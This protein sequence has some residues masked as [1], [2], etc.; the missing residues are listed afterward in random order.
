MTL[1]SDETS[2][3]RA[4]TL[5]Y[6]N[7]WCLARAVGTSAKRHGNT[8]LCSILNS[9]IRKDKP[10]VTVHAVVFANAINMLLVEDRAPQPCLE[11]SSQKN[12][13]C[14]FGLG[15]HLTPEGL[16]VASV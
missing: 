7:Y 15:R 1:L 14:V 2:M 12:I 9:A 16:C 8:E 10:D 11:K 13:S 3:C 5:K 6:T 4:C